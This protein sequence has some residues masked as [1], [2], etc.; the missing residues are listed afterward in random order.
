MVPVNVERRSEVGWVGW[1]VNYV[2]GCSGYVDDCVKT[3]KKVSKEDERGKGFDAPVGFHTRHTTL[4]EI[5]R[6]AARNA[7]AQDST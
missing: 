3:M 2:V 1:G 4:H 7:L 5:V 6:F